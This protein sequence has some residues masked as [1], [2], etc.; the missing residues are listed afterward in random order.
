[1]AAPDRIVIVGGGLA[2]AK[3]AEALRDEGFDG[4]VT[5]VGAEAERPY[6]RPPLSKEVLRGEKDR[7]LL[8]IS[9][10]AYRQAQEIKG[11]AD[12]R[13]TAIYAGAYNRS[14]DTR[15]FYEFIKTMQ[16]YATTLDSTNTLVLSS[17]A[18]FYRYLKSS[19]V[20]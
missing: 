4:D 19:R 5:I 15:S 12:A 16:A 13:A 6:E 18:D 8:R 14:P 11:R 9:S 10:E 7:E 1:M 20:K 2:G 3:A 17:D